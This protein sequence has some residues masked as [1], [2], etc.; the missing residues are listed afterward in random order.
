MNKNRFVLPIAALLMVPCF[1]GC[2]T[3]DVYQASFNNDQ[4]VC[5]HGKQVVDINLI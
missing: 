3:G 2:S 4:I 1:I 5:T